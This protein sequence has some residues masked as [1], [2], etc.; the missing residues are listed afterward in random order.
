M[1]AALYEIEHGIYGSLTNITLNQWFEFWIKE[2]KLESVKNSTII[3]Y[4][5]NY[6]RYVKEVLGSKI[7]VMV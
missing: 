4:A 3:L 2:Y 6:E 5:T 7:L 1:R